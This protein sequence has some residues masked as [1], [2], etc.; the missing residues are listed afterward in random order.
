MNQEELESLKGDIMD[1]FYDLMYGS[2]KYRFDKLH[3]AMGTSICEIFSAATED[4]VLTIEF[5]HEVTKE[6][7]QT[8]H[9]NLVTFAKEF[10]VK[11]A[12]VLAQKA[13]IL[14]DE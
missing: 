8:L 1:V 11:E 9:D 6:Q 12:K 3:S 14:L 10:K 5:G 13:K 2:I 4:F 7:V